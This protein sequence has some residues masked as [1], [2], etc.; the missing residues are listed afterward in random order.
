MKTFFSSGLI[1][2][3]P[4]I[5]NEDDEFGI[6][7]MED[8]S[9]T[10]QYMYQDD[11]INYELDNELVGL[12]DIFRDIIFPDM[13]EYYEE[14]KHLPIWVQ[15]AGQDSNCTLSVKD[16]KEYIEIND[17][18][19]LYRHLYLVDCQFLVG[20]VQNLASAME[21]MFINYYK[22]L[23]SPD[24][25]NFFRSYPYEDG[26]IMVMSKEARSASTYTETYFTK[27][28][29]ILDIMCK[30]CYEIE[31]K[32]TNF[33]SYPKMKSSK[34]LWGNRKKLKIYETKNTIY[35]NCELIKSIES[36][37][38]ET[39]HNGAWELNPKIFIRFDDSCEVERY[40][41]FPY[42]SQ[43]HLS[44]V[45]NRRHF[46]YLNTNDDN[47]LTRQYSH[48][49]FN[50]IFPLIHKEF[51]LRLLETINKIKWIY[52]MNDQTKQL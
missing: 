37:R 7:E 8:K 29:S 47:S 52:L 30:I 25:E 3:I 18:P 38:N 15:E 36:I 45:K 5:L 33:E 44:T 27:A 12:Y 17:I 11:Y 31:N 40:T 19:N 48:I 49:K 51:K 20:T 21:D 16:F 24:A 35:E 43:G 13:D 41:L 50:I 28:Y 4:Y 10:S 46:F 14:I 23:S 9:S 34:V 1:G 39:V 2:D 32:C 22:T 26:I 42:M 6:Q